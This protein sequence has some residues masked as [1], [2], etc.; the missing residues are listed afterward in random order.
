MNTVPS[1]RV[2]VSIEPRDII[3][4]VGVTTL[5]VIASVLDTFSAVDKRAG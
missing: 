4:A 3:D 2:L 5:N 1:D